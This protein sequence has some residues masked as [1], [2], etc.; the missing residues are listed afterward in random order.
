VFTTGTLEDLSESM[1]AL[2]IPKY[3]EWTVTT[4][5]NYFMKYQKT[6]VVF[7]IADPVKDKEL[8]EK[9]E[10]AHKDHTANTPEH[11]RFATQL[12][13]DSTRDS[14]LN[15]LTVPSKDNLP[16]IMAA[17]PV[18]NGKG[19]IMVERF[20]LDKNPADITPNDI[21]DF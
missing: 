8:V 14:L 3:G 1:S 5:M 9:F 16:L 6:Q 12:V 19:N 10:K 20:R 17:K 2:A 13:D 4:H 7:L 11:F 18:G 21:L 15:L